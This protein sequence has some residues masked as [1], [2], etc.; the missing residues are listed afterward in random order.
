METF[1]IDGQSVLICKVVLVWS[2][3]VSHSMYF[4]WTGLDSELR[5]M[6]YGN[7]VW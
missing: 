1:T 7:A 4:L 5:I 2:V 6:T 3:C